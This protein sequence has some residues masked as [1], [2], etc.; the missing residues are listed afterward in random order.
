MGTV[1][2]QDLI[3]EP[4]VFEVSSAVGETLAVS[5]YVSSLWLLSFS[6]FAAG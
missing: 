4:A 3:G 5:L 6:H 2:V 1:A